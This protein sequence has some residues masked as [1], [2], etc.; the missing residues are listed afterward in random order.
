MSDVVDRHAISGKYPRNGHEQLLRFGLGVEHLGLA[1]RELD[2]R[3]DQGYEM[4]R[5]DFSPALLGNQ[6]QLESH[7]QARLVAT[8]D[9]LC[10][11]GGLPRCP[12]R[13]SPMPPVGF[14]IG[15]LGAK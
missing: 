11:P 5:V 3:F 1:I 15:S 9:L 10:Y 8:D 7:G 14:T 2:T 6:E 12:F 13:T 4:T